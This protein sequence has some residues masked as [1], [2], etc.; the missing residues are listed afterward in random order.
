M[1]AVTGDKRA[2]DFL[3][4]RLSVAILHGNAASV[5][6]SVIDDDV[7]ENNVYLDNIAY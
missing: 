5:L 4:Q 6:G 7:E 1:I 3:F 2:K